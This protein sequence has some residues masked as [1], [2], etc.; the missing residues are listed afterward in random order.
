MI[1]PKPRFVNIF[2]DIDEVANAN[3]KRYK[4][5]DEILQRN[6]SYLLIT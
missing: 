5:V 3:E 1:F 2:E 4:T 6:G